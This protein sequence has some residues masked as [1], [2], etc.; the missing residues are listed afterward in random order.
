MDTRTNL[1]KQHPQAYQALLDMNKASSAAAEAAGID[2]LLVELVKIRASQI[3]NCA[4][5]LRMHT[6]DALKLGEEADRLAVLPAWRESSGYFSALERASLA[7][8]EAVVRIDDGGVEDGLYARI[9]E[10]LTP[11]QISAVSWVA[12]TIGVFNRVAI[13][14]R[15][16]VEA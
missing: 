14:S 16:P 10:F 12:S 6:R 9:S 4:F 7:L 8:A 11:E 3:N 15:Y 13:A 1:S 5:C 2:P